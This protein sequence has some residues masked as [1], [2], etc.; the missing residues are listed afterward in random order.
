MSEAPERIWAEPGMPRY[1]D[2]PNELYTVEYV[3]ADRIEELEA[4]LAECEAR[5]VKAVEQEMV[6][7]CNAYA[8]DGNM[9]AA[10]AIHDAWLCVQDT[11]AELKG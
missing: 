10:T 11:L 5:L 7:V 2:E 6:R 4:E 1:T 9:I 8:K 3:R